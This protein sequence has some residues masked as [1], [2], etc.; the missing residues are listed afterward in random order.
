MPR[1]ERK[2][3]NHDEHQALIKRVGYAVIE[4][5]TLGASPMTAAEAAA[6]ARELAANEG[7]T[8]VIVEP[9]GII[10]SS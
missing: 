2:T 1:I 8:F 3:L 4:E 6:F 5:S 7:K 10:E 9:Y